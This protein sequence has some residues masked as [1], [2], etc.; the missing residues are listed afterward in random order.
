MAAFFALPDDFFAA[1]L[2]VVFFAA[3]RVVLVFAAPPVLAAVFFAAVLLIEFVYAQVN[4]TL[5]LQLTHL[6]PADGTTLYGALMSVTGIYVV[7]LTPIVV[8]ATRRFAPLVN[9]TTAPLPYAV[10]SASVVHPAREDSRR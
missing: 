6:F 1:F 9:Q 7:V 2:A 3:V 5:P 4:F 8:A 10:R